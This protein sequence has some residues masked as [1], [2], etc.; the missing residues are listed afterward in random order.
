MHVRFAQI[1]ERVAAA[2]GYSL[3]PKAV[4]STV[5]VVKADHV[6]GG[7]TTNHVRRAMSVSVATHL[8]TNSPFW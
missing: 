3:L 7:A 2:P 8:A 5:S 1:K 4:T 6:Q